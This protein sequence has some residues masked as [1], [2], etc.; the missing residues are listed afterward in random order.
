MVEYIS[1]EEAH[2]R[3]DEV[4]ALMYEDSKEKIFNAI[5]GAI[6]LGEYLVPIETEG[7]RWFDTKYQDEFKETMKELGYKVSISGDYSKIIIEW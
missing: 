3:T 1:A 5:H 4:L 2:G 7:F 6:A